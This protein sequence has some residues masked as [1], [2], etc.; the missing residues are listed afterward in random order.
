[1]LLILAALPA[2]CEEVLFRGFIQYSC[3]ALKRRWMIPC[4]VG[5]L[6][7]IVHF[8]LFRV[9]PTALIGIALSYIMLRTNNIVLPMIGHFLNNAIAASLMYWSTKTMIT[10]PEIPQ[11]GFSPDMLIFVLGLFLFFGSVLPFILCGSDVLL[12]KKDAAAKHKDAVIVCFL[13]ASL[14]LLS[15]IALMTFSVKMTPLTLA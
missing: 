8:H 11:N 3:S 9:L 12:R 7:G 13:L 1:M 2:F 4:V 15:G 10:K 5:L 6:F 14:L